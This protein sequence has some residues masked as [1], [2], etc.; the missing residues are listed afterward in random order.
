MKKKHTRILFIILSI[1]ILLIFAVNF[2]I[3]L[4]L[5]HRL[6]DYIQKNSNYAVEYK[7]LKVDV[8]SGDILATNLK[9]KTKNTKDHKNIG[10]DGNVDSLKIT[11]LGLYDAI[12]NKKIASSNLLLV[13]PHLHITLPKPG[14]EKTGKKRNPVTFENINIKDGDITIYRH[15]KQKYLAVNN[16][17]LKVTDLQLTEKGVKE[18]LPVVF[19]TY[20]I[21]GK[22]FYFQPDNVYLLKAQEINT[23]DG[24]MSITMFQMTP[25]MS[26]KQFIHYF[27]KKR[28]LF[29]V[30]AH[31][32][33]FKD[34]KLNDNKITLSKVKFTQ[35]N[36]KINTTTAKPQEKEQSFTY[37]VNMED[38][39]I[40]N[41]KVEILKPDTSRLFAAGLLN[42]SITE[43][44]IDE[45][46]AKGNI[47]FAYEKF[48]V[49][50]K[51]LNYISN[52]QNIKVN[53]IAA[54][55]K[56]VESKGISVKPTVHD[57]QQPTMDFT[58]SH[59]YATVNHWK[60]ENSKLKMDVKDIVVDG[61]N[62]S[63]APAKHKQNKKNSISGIDFPLKVKNI[64]I[65]NSNLALDK[66]NGAM[67]FKNL[68]A[69]FNNVQITEESAKRK[70]PLEVGSY[71]LTSNSFN[72]TTK[73]Y[74]LSAGLTKFNH[75]QFQANNFSVKPRYS[76][77]QFI[78][79]IPTEK[80]LYDISVKQISGNGEWNLFTNKETVNI[81]QVTINGADANIF[82]SKI[83]KDDESIKPMY[84][85]LLRR[86]KIPLIVKNLDLK[87]SRLE[88]EEDTKKSDGPGKLIFSNFNMNIKNLNSGKG[89][90][91]NTLIP[92]DI[93][94]SFMNV[95][96]MHVK[97]TLNTASMDDTFT[98]AGNISN[99]PAPN[100]NRFI[101]PYLK[102]R[103]T[104]AIQRLAFDFKGN[105]R[106][107]GGRF[108]LKHKELKIEVLTKSKEKNVVLSAIANIFVKT[109]SGNYPESVIVENVERDPTKSFFNLFWKGVESGLK[110]ALIGAS[111]EK[112]EK[113]IKETVS[114]AKDAID[115]NKKALENVKSSVQAVKSDI[116]E[117]FQNVKEDIQEKKEDIKENK[118]CFLKRIFKKKEKAKD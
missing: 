4:W 53:S 49:S 21:S 56:S 23:K 50:G 15:T 76:R 97:W 47:P 57:P 44:R 74:T 40:Q 2:G 10:V 114:T 102:I 20:D 29:D 48:L 104:G 39:A 88:Y 30:T 61:L 45:Q 83:P 98:I 11:R 118:P 28:N 94:C 55:P 33:E 111:A 24:Q 17:R 115:Q 31:L 95:S 25:L 75:G 62:G 66:G 16:L 112:A 38:V 81:S 92:I 54:N 19:D 13:K 96:P 42:L 3:N 7:E 35:P 14:D 34:I 87:N 12:F 100:I 64:T 59:I 60:M 36:I 18:K 109:D 9:I 82:R 65:K 67:A 5:Q 51:D 79:M 22:N 93:N 84:S 6:P 80:D 117:A 107:I 43:M 8:S 103:A 91:R 86:I 72:Y 26:Y 89:V 78:R 63:L 27:P 71:R 70:M 58:L 32:L 106:G 90:G 37:V 99:L 46:T 69:Q 110:K 105:K 1:L 113:N 101:E 85:E 52:N 116:K 108:N 77:S 41:G 73:F 68:A